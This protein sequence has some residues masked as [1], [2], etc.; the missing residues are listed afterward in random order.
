MTTHDYPKGVV[1]PVMT[2][3]LFQLRTRQTHLGA[4]LVNVYYYR[5]NPNSDE[6]VLSEIATIFTQAVFNTILTVQSGSAVGV[7][8]RVR[9]FGEVFEH[10]ED[11]SA[12]VGE[13]AGDAMNSF[14]A[15]SFILLRNTIDIRNGG[16]RFGGL[17][18]SSVAGN[19]ATGAVLTDLQLVADNLASNL[20]TVSGAVLIPVIYRAGSFLDGSWFGGNFGEAVFRG[21][22]S[23]VSRRETL[24]GE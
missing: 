4:S 2:D 16:K 7:D 6:P 21:V 22:T 13:I 17:A 18:E 14:S 9:E 12:K 23:Q 3:R 11:Y 8:L 15:W 19:D 5:H 20:E 1:M 24:T 10:I